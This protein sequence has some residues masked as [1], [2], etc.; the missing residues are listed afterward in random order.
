MALHPM[1]GR[2]RPLAGEGH[3][4]RQ[5]R[6]D[7]GMTSPLDFSFKNS[8]AG[9]FEEAAYP[10]QPGRYRYMPYL[11]FGH[12]E[13]CLAVEKGPATCSFEDAGRVIQFRVKAIPAYGALVIDA[14]LADSVDTP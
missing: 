12:Y 14:I 3:G 11:G 10:L 7:S 4:D 8:V 1:I 6:R 9:Y 5:T 2:G 13:L